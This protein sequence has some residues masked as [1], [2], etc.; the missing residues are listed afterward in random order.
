MSV[1]ASAWR[2]CLVS[3]NVIFCDRTFALATSK[4]G[5]P[6]RGVRYAY[7]PHDF[8]VGDTKHC[9]FYAEYFVCCAGAKNKSKNCCYVERSRHPTCCVMFYPI[10]FIYYNIVIV[11]FLIHFYVVATSYFNCMISY[12]VITCDHATMSRDHTC[13]ECKCRYSQ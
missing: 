9:W 5:H 10:K 3:L 7:L 4:T 2:E 6:K 11:Y 12:L 1:R 13:R 8:L